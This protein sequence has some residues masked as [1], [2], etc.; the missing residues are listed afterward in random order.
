MFGKL[1]GAMLASSAA[2]L[3]VPAAA[4]DGPK[5]DNMLQ[6]LS[7]HQMMYQAFGDT[8]EGV[9]HLER[10]FSWNDLLSEEI[11]DRDVRVAAVEVANLA[12]AQA[13]EEALEK[14][15]DALVKLMVAR[16]Q[17]CKKFED[18]FIYDDSGSF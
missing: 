7:F 15:E 9:V 4:D 6:C 1:F 12:L 13:A 8:S 2:A 11:S 14:G 16:G 5:R 3:P 10:I 18:G 17:E